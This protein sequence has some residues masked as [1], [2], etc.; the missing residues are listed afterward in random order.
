MICAVI[1]NETIRRQ[2]RRAVQPLAK[3]MSLAAVLAVFAAALA[4]GSSQAA[5]TTFG[6]PL[7][8]RATLNTTENLNYVGTYTEVPTSPEAPSGVF[9]TNHWGT[10]TA[11]WNVALPNGNAG[12]PASGQAVKVSLEGCAQPAPGGPSPLTQIHFQDITPLPGGG[13]RVNLTSQPFE[14]PVCGQNGASGTTVT[15]YEPINLCVNQ[16]DYVAFNDEGGYVPYIYRSGV[17][18]QVMGQAPG[19][20]MDS[21]IRANGTDNGD[22]MAS[23]D[24]TANDGFAINRN[25]QLM[26][27]V[28]LGTGPDAR[29]VCPGGSKEAP[30]V[31][32]PIDVHPQ[33]DGINHSRIVAVAVYCRTTPECKGAV[34]LSL[35]GKQVSVGSGDFSILG[36]TTSHVS[37]RV[38]P[39][40]MGPI[41]R[42]DGVTTTLTAVVAGKTFTQKIDVKI[43]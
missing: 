17:P 25:E 38:V 28:T 23:D 15:S 14:M 32:P 6:S 12:A 20:T 27:Q 4:P 26:M 24:T 3:P 8:L 33:T 35:A 19:S 2:L 37:I 40:L 36:N 9:H 11:L 1:T 18:Y 41:R 30:P 29:Y 21:F 10:D 5:I 34:T 43:L 22:T 31:L 7:S 39:S 13:A 16:G 42:D